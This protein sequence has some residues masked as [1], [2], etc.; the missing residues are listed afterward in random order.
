MGWK[1]TPWL[2]DGEVPAEILVGSPH[3]RRPLGNELCSAPAWQSEG[4][5]EVQTTQ[6]CENSQM[7][8]EQGDADVILS[9]AVASQS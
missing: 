8:S 4:I 2:E 1:T 3:S 6:K 7:V 9:A 5:F